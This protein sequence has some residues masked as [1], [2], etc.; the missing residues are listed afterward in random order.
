MSFGVQTGDIHKPL[1]LNVETANLPQI[2]A[3]TSSVA[4]TRVSVAELL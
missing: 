2:G 4:Q 1:L 3:R